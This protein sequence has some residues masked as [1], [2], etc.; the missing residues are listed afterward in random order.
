MS[1]RS[2]QPLPKS[3]RGAAM[4]AALCLAMVFAISLSS[5]LA[6]CYTSLTMSTR[7]IALMHTSELAETGVEKAL[8]AYNNSDWNNWTLSGSTA[9]QTMT[10]TSS[11]LVLTSTSPTPLNYGSG[12]TG[13]VAIT[14]QNYNTTSPS[15]RA[16][17]T[18]TLPSYAGNAAPTT[19]SSTVNYTAPA[20]PSTGA[21]PVFVNAV[22]AMTGTVRFRSA[23]TVDSYDSVQAATALVNGS[24]CQ[25]I[26]VGTTNWTLIGAAS[27]NVGTVFT[28]TGPGT[29]TGTAYV[30]YNNTAVTSTT[31]VNSGYSAVVLSQDSST[32]SATVRLGN[33]VVHGYA[34]GY[35]PYYPGTTNWLSYSTSGK[36]IG[37]L[38]PTGTSIDSSRL[39]TSPVPYQP[40]VLENLPTSWSS[41]PGA[42]TTDGYTLNRTCTLGST[43]ATVPKVYSAGSGVYL[44]SGQIVTIQGPVV[45][46]C[47]GDVTISGTSQIRLTT[48][49]ASLQIF[50]EYGNLNLGGNG[51]TNTNAFPLPKKVSILDTTNYWSTATIST[52]T[53][54]YGVIYFPYMPIAVTATSPTIYGSIVGSSVSFTNSPTFHYDLALRSPMPSY[55]SAI[56][57]QS[58]SAF[59]YLSAPAG[60]S[61]MTASVP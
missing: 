3:Q 1:L 19:T 44:T 17:A 56:P 15:V 53:P 29:G 5:Y 11:G 16:Q 48:P 32:S 51:I 34:V 13:Q 50:I 33:A 37:P 14:I 18:F 43:L 4:L 40:M 57:L 31:Y 60:F 35:N 21:G 26:S 23:G 9:T 20:S 12:M 36:L 42:A 54:F 24:V 46:I 27:N 28:A 59:D 10:M 2:R 61:S 47:Y 8:Y 49:Q 30:N 25:I 52:N 55:T 38:T 7:S 6:L 45:L 58:G 39:V 22:A 41:L